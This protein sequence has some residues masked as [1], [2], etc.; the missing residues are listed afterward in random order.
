MNF[1]RQITPPAMGTVEVISHDITIPA[2]VAQI[3]RAFAASVEQVGDVEFL[4]GDNEAA[5]A[6]NIWHYIRERIEYRRDADGDEDIKTA[7]R[8][9]SDGYGDCDDGSVLA[10]AILYKLGHAPV[11]Y[12]IAQSGGDY[13][14]IFTCSG[15]SPRADHSQIRGYAIDF[16]PEIPGPNRIAPNITKVMALRYLDGVTPAAHTPGTIRG[17]AGLAAVSSLTA[18]LMARRD[19][20][21]NLYQ[22]GIWDEDAAREL[23]IVLAVIQMNGT[24][25]QVQILPL[26]PYIQ[27]ITPAGVI[28]WKDGSPWEEIETYLSGGGLSG[29]GR[30]G[31]K[32]DPAAPAKPKDP[33]KFLQVVSKFNPLTIAIREALKAVLALNLFRLASRMRWLFISPSDP[34]AKGVNPAFLARFQANRGK[35]EKAFELL[36]GDPAALKAAIDKGAAKGARKDLKGLGVV[37]TVTLA[38]AS[39]GVIALVEAVGGPKALKE[40]AKEL[41]AAKV[42]NDPAAEQDEL[43]ADDSPKFGAKAVEF[44]KNLLKGGDKATKGTPQDSGF[45]ST[46]QAQAAYNAAMGN[47]PDTDPG[48]DGGKDNTMMYV[49]GAAGLLIALGL[50]S[51]SNS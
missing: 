1:T 49:A 42:T 33:G 36:G 7:R 3:R 16:V 40:L 26:M 10:A 8:T 30:I 6:A 28:A 12:I 5:T 29:L 31:K 25:E 2:T 20:L 27:D 9:M 48:T 14:H 19:E 51:R 44:I 37:E 11:S 41:T 23:R 18:D 13:S 39:T 24:P 34:A 47:K 45:Q 35:V 4:R 32:K 22:S 50:A 38:T 46:E 21:I 17:L 15:D 43:T